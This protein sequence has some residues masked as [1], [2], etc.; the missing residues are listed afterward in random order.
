MAGGTYQ[1]NRLALAPLL[2]K[3]PERV[4]IPLVSWLWM[5]ALLCALVGLA[6][7]AIGG[8]FSVLCA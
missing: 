1:A 3:V 5:G 8:W 7:M 6:G 2:Q 4:E